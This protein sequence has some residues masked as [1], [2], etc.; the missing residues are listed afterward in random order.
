MVRKIAAHGVNPK[1]GD[2][3]VRSN[4]P[5]RR[6]LP[7][8]RDFLSLCGW[9]LAG[10]NTAPLFGADRESSKSSDRKRIVVIGAGLAGL[11]AARELK[12]HGHE[13]VVLEA[14]NRVGGRIWTSRKWHDMPLDLGATWIHGIEGNPI[15]SIA[16]EVGAKRL[17]T[18]YD[19]SITYDTT[20]QPIGDTQERHLAQLR[21]QVSQALK[22]AQQTEEDLS[23]RQAIEPLQQPFAITSESYRAIDFILSGECEH[24]YS[25]NSTDLSAHWFDSVKE[26]EGEDVLFADGFG[27]ITEHLARDLDVNLGQDVQRIDWESSPVRVITRTAEFVADHA[28]VTLPLGVLKAKKVVFSPKL[29]RKT[30]TAIDAL[31]FGVLNKCYL[32]FE[33]AFWPDDVDW[34]EYIPS[35]HGEWTEWVSFQRVA[36]MP[37]LLGFNAA[38]HGKFVEAWTDTQIVTS[39]MKTL[40]T[41]FG[42]RTPDPVDHQITRWAADPYALGAYSFNAVGSTPTMRDELAAPLESR[43]FFAGEATERNYFGTAHGAVLSGLRAAMEVLSI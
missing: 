31:G 43:I 20:G 25:G 33:Q 5:S 3:V 10:G 15:T 36:K 37:I 17:V 22:R 27:V 38:A 23:V 18:S 35:R 29:P 30:L 9:V 32:R 4:D 28:I 26:Y 1:R 21:R 42:T 19:K 13:V 12:K 6:S 39:A 2:H 40:D 24:E 7:W 14:R 16:D 8:R 34:I 41:I 11:V